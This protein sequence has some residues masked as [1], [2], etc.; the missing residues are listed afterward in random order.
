MYMYIVERM[1][2]REREVNSRFLLRL[3][4]GDVHATVAIYTWL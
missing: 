3:I 1:G 4:A 2:I